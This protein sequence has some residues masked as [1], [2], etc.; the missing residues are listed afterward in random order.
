M[1]FRL[2][3]ILS[4][5]A[6]AVGSAPALHSQ[7]RATN[8]EQM[9]IELASASNL[10]GDPARY[11][12][13]AFEPLVIFR[14]IFFSDAPKGFWGI[15]GEEF[16]A[17]RDSAQ[18][19]ALQKTLAVASLVPERKMCSGH[20]LAVEACRTRDLAGSLFFTPAYV[21]D[22]TAQVVFVQ[23]GVMHNIYPNYRG[24]DYEFDRVFIELVREKAGWKVL[25]T[26]RVQK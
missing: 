8:Q 11:E 6:L 23:M 19:A 21:K 20:V 1:K 3:T 17:G 13:F 18:V 10:G 14:D 26:V 22:D 24:R 2:C 12:R 4:W 5:L 7:I 25:R 9:L 16:L 15:K